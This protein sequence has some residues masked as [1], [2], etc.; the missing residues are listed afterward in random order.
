MGSLPRSHSAGSPNALAPVEPRRWRRRQRQPTARR[1]VPVQGRGGPITARAEVGGAVARQEGWVVLRPLRL[2]T[3]RQYPYPKL[4][5]SCQDGSRGIDRSAGF[6]RVSLALERRYG[7]TTDQ[8]S[9]AQMAF[10][11][12]PHSGHTRWSLSTG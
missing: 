6:G 1:V 3:C 12:E 7:F 5:G 9:L 4:G 8:A 11:P 10:G 2:N